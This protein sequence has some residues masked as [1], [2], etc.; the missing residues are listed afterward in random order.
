MSV[1]TALA[2]SSEISSAAA[3]AFSA[4]AAQVKMSVVAGS[5]TLSAIVA[6]AIFPSW[7][8]LIASFSLR[9]AARMHASVLS[10]S[11]WALACSVPAPADSANVR[12]SAEPMIAAVLQRR[13]RRLT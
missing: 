7:M 12:T 4:W 8:Y 6:F 1:S 10:R 13:R 3:A 9:R 11:G 5:I 2:S